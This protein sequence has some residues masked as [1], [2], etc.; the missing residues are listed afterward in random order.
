MHSGLDWIPGHGCLRS[1]L[2]VRNTGKRDRLLSC[3]KNP[4]VTQLWNPEHMG[5]CAILWL[6]L[7]PHL[8]Q[9]SQAVTQQYDTEYKVLSSY[10]QQPVPLLPVMHIP[11][12]RKSP[13]ITSLPGKPLLSPLF[14]YFTFFSG[15]RGRERIFSRLKPSAQHRA[16]CGAPSHDPEITI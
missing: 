1:W 15:G 6:V 14:Y 13:F 5:A 11:L 16:Q 9:A 4:T 3:W 8:G 2:F 7:K 12:S 10:P